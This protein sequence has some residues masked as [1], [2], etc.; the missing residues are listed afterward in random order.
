MKALEWK[1]ESLF[2]LNQ[3]ILPEQTEW[4]ECK[5]VERVGEAIKRL[6]VRCAPAI[7][8][9]AGFGLVLAARESKSKEEFLKK[10]LI[11]KEA[12]PTAVN[13]MWAIDKLVKKIE[14][15]AFEDYLGEL[16]KEAQRLLEEDILMNHTMAQYGA[17]LFDKP[18]TIL[19]HCNTGS[20]ATAGYGTALGVIRKLWEE[21]KLI[22]VYVDETRPLLQGARLTAYELVTEQ[23]PAILISDNMAGW[24][25][26]TKKIDAIIVGADRIA[27]NGDTANKIGTYSLAVLAKAHNIPFYI[28]APYSTFDDEIHSGGQIVIEEREG[29]EIRKIGKKWIAPREIETFNPAFDVTPGELITGIITD[30]GVFS[31]PYENTLKNWK[32]N[33]K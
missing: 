31:Y 33:N 13:L 14:N 2:L 22:E 3:T 29:N 1:N 19:T 6:E 25:M 26:K 21:E 18:V 32:E 27:Q 24:V 15:I 23:I 28:A 16:E 11:L 7:G 8:V 17:Q 20:L 4:I 5:S 12:R 9:A 10:A 30:K